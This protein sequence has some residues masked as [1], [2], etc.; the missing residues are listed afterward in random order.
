MSTFICADKNLVR[1]PASFESYI[2]AF[3]CNL[4]G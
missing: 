3:E 4:L 1:L 2:V